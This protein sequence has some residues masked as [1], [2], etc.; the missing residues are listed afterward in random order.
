MIPLLKNIMF[1]KNAGLLKSEIRAMTQRSRFSDWLPWLC[2]NEKAGVWVNRDDSTGLLWECLPWTFGTQKG[3]EL[4]EGL[5]H[6][7]IPYGSVL[8]FILYADPRIDD[9]LTN[10]AVD[11]RISND[12]V[13]SALERKK[14][15][16]S[17]GTCGLDALS[18]NPVRHFRLF[19]ALKIP[20]G[21]VKEV[22]ELVNLKHNIGEILV[23][24]G[25]NPSP[26]TADG[27]ISVMA[28]LFNSDIEKLP[29]YDMKSNGFKDIAD[30]IIFAQN[31]IEVNFK[32][33]RMGNKIFRCLTP[34]KMPLQANAMT[35]NAIS[36]GMQGI[37]SDSSQH[38]SPFLLTVNC[39]FEDLKKLLH[40]KCNF[41]LGQ[42]AVGSLS[43]VLFRT[44][45]EYMWATDELEQ[46]TPFVRI[47]PVFWQISEQGN[48]SDEAF[49]RSRRIWESGGFSMQEDMG[50][51]TPLLIS[52]LPFGMY[53]ADNNTQA[54]ARSF[55]V[56]DKAAVRLFPVQA[57]L[58]TTSKP[59]SLFVGR[60]GQM[61]SLDLFDRKA[62]NHNALVAAG[63]GSGKSFLIN[64]VLFDNWASGAFIRIVDI[65]DSYKK[66]C[67]I[68]DGRYISFSRDSH[69]VLNPFSAI[70]DIDEDLHIV[71][72]IISQ[73]A[74]SYTNVSPSEI[75]MS[76]IKT[77]VRATWDSHGNDGQIDHVHDFL[78]HDDSQDNKL[79]EQCE[80]LAICLLDFTS[81]G[82]YGRWF[83]GKSTL[84][85]SKDR[86]V[87]L[88]LEDLKEQKEL[89]SVII[90]QLISYISG[91]L[92]RSDRTRKQIIVFDEAWQFLDKGSDGIMKDVIEGGY[93]RARKYNGSF[94]TITQ[95]LM[96]LK[97]FGATG[98]VI[99]TNSAFR[100]LLRSTDYASAR[101]AGLIDY[102]DFYMNLLESV[103]TAR[104]RY[105]EIFLDTPT[106]KGVVRLI[107]DPYSYWMF[108]SDAQD[109]SR[110]NNL[111][112]QGKS[113][114]QAFEELAL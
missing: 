99:L 5:F 33:I 47:M 97:K 39:V 2:F 104:G 16:F 4:L 26:V 79:R 105:S 56:H 10:H 13:S 69:I 24:A 15:M 55:I 44:Q 46:G 61:V 14:K 68:T 75:E 113:Y 37:I 21:P 87:V 63:S 94:I 81:S 35:M 95:G 65:G 9:I 85:I 106:G 84:D 27:L 41:V 112:K 31:D 12:V 25:L 111:V 72:A 108:T 18:G 11:K 57:D 3:Y 19:V 74:Y 6:A 22:K 103:N 43:R 32:H 90:L 42:K 83:S 101:R 98:D 66:L 110:I 1:G 23:G 51:L 82:T 70:C 40:T 62:D 34:K 80:Y 96:D 36:G 89:F 8:Q 102:D 59:V 53:P 52:S 7:G 17:D 60:K 50:I 30:Q 109:N 76:L 54:L 38:L 77:A 107:V 67:S 93:R 58:V 114:A 71:S 48:V 28:G 78:L 73:M 20:D 29:G 92:Y 86:F 64:S 100:F 49:S 91:D 88:E 45:E